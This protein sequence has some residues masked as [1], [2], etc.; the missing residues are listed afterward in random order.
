MKDILT[1]QKVPR[2]DARQ[3]QNNF[4]DVLNNLDALP[5][6]K[7]EISSSSCIAVGYTVNTFV[8]R[9]DAMKSISFNLQWVMLLG[10]V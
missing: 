1:L 9:Q 2:Y 6:L 8:K 3:V 7:Q 5:L 4:V 10:K